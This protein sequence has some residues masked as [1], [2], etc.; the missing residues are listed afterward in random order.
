MTDSA[1]EVPQDPPATAI[2]SGSLADGRRP[3]R[4]SAAWLATGIGLVLLLLLLIFI[5]QNPQRARI[6]YLWLDGTIPVG[7]AL[8]GAAVLG[9]AVV[10]IAGGSRIVQLRRSV[11]RAGKRAN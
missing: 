9:G 5:L 4:L 11:R 3:T 6:H 10:S 8:F 1:Q 2:P 7:V